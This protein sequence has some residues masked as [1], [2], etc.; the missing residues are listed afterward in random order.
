[1]LMKSGLI[2]KLS[3]NSPGIE[4]CEKKLIEV[5][6]VVIDILHVKQRTE[7]GLLQFYFDGS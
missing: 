4:I 6:K 2:N 5:I 1:M 3:A 7:G